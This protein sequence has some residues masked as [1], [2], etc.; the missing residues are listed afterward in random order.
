[1][2]VSSFIIVDTVSI[3]DMRFNCNLT[4]KVCYSK[5][6]LSPLIQP[7]NINALSPALLNNIGGGF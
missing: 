6:S 1:M 5:Y 7:N 4:C 3:N 2:V